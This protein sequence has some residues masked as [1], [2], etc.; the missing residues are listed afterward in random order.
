MHES[1]RVLLWEEGSSFN[2]TADI[3]VALHTKFTYARMY[4]FL[5]HCLAYCTFPKLHCALNE[6]TMLL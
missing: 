6:M 2:S 3:Q 5:T 1:L 4:E